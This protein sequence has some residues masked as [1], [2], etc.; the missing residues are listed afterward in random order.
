MASTESQ[1]ARMITSSA[2]LGKG[3]VVLLD[4]TPVML[5]TLT[6]VILKNIMLNT[7]KQNVEE[8]DKYPE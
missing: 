4:W 6:E 1:L 8:T 2:P 3:Q 7:V 5:V